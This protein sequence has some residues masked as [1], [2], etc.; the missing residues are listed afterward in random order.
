MN[1]ATK[2]Y[3]FYGIALSKIPTGTGN[4]SLNTKIQVLQ[5]KYPAIFSSVSLQSGHFDKEIINA[6]L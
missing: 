2:F 6:L 4:C 1:L 5:V 3:H